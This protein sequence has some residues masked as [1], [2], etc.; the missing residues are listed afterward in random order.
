MVEPPPR[1]PWEEWVSA[2][3]TS[4]MDWQR[5]AIMHRWPIGR[6]MTEHD[7]DAAIYAA[8]HVAIR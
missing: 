1:K 3:H 7:F 4:P 8:A 5:T 6:E 2:K